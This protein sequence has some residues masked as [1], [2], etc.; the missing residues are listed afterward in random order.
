MKKTVLLMRMFFLG[1]LFISATACS[2]DDDGDNGGGNDD[3]NIVEVALETPELASLVLAL[4]AADGDLVNLLQTDGPFTVLA[5]NNAAFAKFLSD[6][7]FGSVG[8]VPSDL[9]EAILLNHVIQ[10]DVSSGDLAGLGRGYTSTSASGANN[11]PISIYFNATNGVRFN[12]VSAVTSGGADIDASNGTIHIVDAVIPIPNIVDHAEANED[13]RSLVSA[14]Q[15]ADG[16]LLNVLKGN[17]P[18]TVL[19][20]DNDA[21][22]T[23]LDGADIGGI[24]KAFLSKLLLNHVIGANVSAADLVAEGSGY[25]KTSANGPRDQ[26]LSLYFD[27]DEGVEFNGI[28][29]V[30][31][32]DIVGS[33]G[34]IHA[35]ETV[36]DLPTVVTFALADPNF[37]TLVS[38]LTELTPG[39]DY[40]TILSRTEAGNPIDGMSPN[41]TVFAPTDTAFE[42]LFEE[43]GDVPGA[44]VLIDVL[45]YHIVT[46]SNIISTDLTG[47]DE[48]TSFQGDTFTITTPGTGENIAD[49]DDA[50]GRPDIGIIGVD[51]QANNGVIHVLNKVMLPNL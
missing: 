27:T 30:Y 10:A 46:E 13:F 26:K 34:I 25:T 41:F 36:I 51:V 17:G 23:F 22:G 43:L 5:P 32:A 44:S 7:G 14:L 35:V 50:A 28:S 45:D 6:N 12:N 31:E 39:K 21:F 18:F 42:D 37:E 9:L 11:L 24:D 20:P 29:D 3:P 1:I 15:A 2:D 48:V 49:V 19:A 33:N 4:Q 8:E 38:A 47:N 16:D 40:A